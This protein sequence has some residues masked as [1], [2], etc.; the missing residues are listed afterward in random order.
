MRRIISLWFVSHFVN[1]PAPDMRHRKSLI[2]CSGRESRIPDES[3]LR[4]ELNFRRTNAD[5]DAHLSLQKRRQEWKKGNPIGLSINMRFQLLRLN[6]FVFALLASALCVPAVAQ[7]TAFTY[8]GRLNDNGSPATGSFDL[9]FVL[10]DSAAAGNQVGSSIIHSAV[11]TTNGLFTA[12]LDFGPGAFA[13]SGRWLEIGVRTN[14]GSMFTTLNPRQALLPSPY[15]I[16]SSSAATANTAVV[17]N[18]FN[19][20]LSGD[21]GGPQGATVLNSIRG[22]SALTVTQAV[23]AVNAA[24]SASQPNVIVKRDGA[25]GFSAGA[26]QAASVHGNGVGLTNLNGAALLNGSVSTAKIADGAVN[27]AHLADGAVGA[28]QLAAGAVNATHLVAG[29]AAANLKAAGQ[30]GVASGGLVLSA[31]ENTAL[32][33]AGYVRIGIA[34][35][36]DAWQ[37]RGSGPPPAGRGRHTAVWTG[38]EMIVWGGGGFGV[39]IPGIAGGGRYNPAGNHWTIFATVGTPGAPATRY[40]HTAVWTGT[41]MIVWGGYNGNN[42][43]DG[44]RYNPATDSWSPVATA[45]AP[46]ARYMHTA[47]WTGTEMI[48]WGGY[49]GGYNG[50]FILNLGNGTC[51]NDGARYNPAGNNWTTVTTAD[52]PEGR[53][54]HTAVWTGTEMIVWGGRNVGAIPLNDGGCYNPAD[55]LWTPV[56]TNGAAVARYSHTAVWTGSEMIIWAGLGI[57]NDNNASYQPTGGRFNPTANSWTP[58][59]VVGSPPLRLYNTAVWTG[60][61]MIIWGGFNGSPNAIGNGGRYN[62]ANDN[63][64]AMATSGAPAGRFSHIAVW[65]GSEMIIWGGYHHAAGSFNYGTFFDDGG[66][67]RPSDNSWTAVNANGVPAARHHH[68]AVWTGSEMIIWGGTGASHFDDGGRFNPAANLWTPIS[69]AGAPAP[70]YS[71]TA[72]WTGTEMIVWG[73]EN[74]TGF[75]PSGGRYN[76]AGDAWTA[77]SLTG[78]PIARTGHT[79]VWTGTEMIVW[80]GSTFGFSGLSDGGRYN[81]AG[82]SWTVVTTTAAPVGREEHTAVW[83]GSEMIIWGGVSPGS[84]RN[85]G[86]RYNPAGDSWTLLST[87]GAPVGRRYHTALWTGTEMI[88]WGGAPGAYADGGRYNPGSDSWTAVTTSTTPPAGRYGHTAVWTGSEMIVWG[89]ADNSYLNDGGRYSPT[90]NSWNPMTLTG[91]PNARYYHTAV[92]TGREMII[93]GGYSTGIL[94]NDTHSY[95]PALKLILYQ[96]TSQVGGSA[97]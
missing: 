31:A 35:T 85:D 26:I 96:A 53:V 1:H 16:Y 19:G 7:N 25:G 9:R 79:A 68:T 32:V 21:V 81:P 63:W 28:N 56:T 48:I 3:R 23:S 20:S 89:G 50:G 39:S 94:F 52:A 37:Q 44:S 42:L 29:A 58:M 93:W 57:G 12:V 33:N 2:F 8:Q 66:R 69:S 46:S 73:G 27:A 5:S 24:T 77:V 61:E 76:P 64:S 45:G 84:Y 47:V 72:V 36:S 41:E 70:R 71:H 91:K 87:T 65:T 80:G 88:V 6:A 90:D 51:L 17:A 38:S 59:S 22:V 54:N 34:T 97:R 15:A 82:D 62:P 18:S 49:D 75:F 14:G 11:A 86:G 10:F 74:G 43:N 92:W 13:G 78:G 40:D 4:P 30:S 55:N 95:T 67:Y 83:T 60:S